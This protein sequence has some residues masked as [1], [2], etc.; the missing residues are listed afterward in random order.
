MRRCA[1][2]LLGVGLSLC[3][4]AS[5]QQPVATDSQAA[6]AQANVAGDR[7]RHAE[8]LLEKGDFTA[9][10]AELAN[11]AKTSPHDAR[12]QYDLG[13]TEEHN[14]ENA[15]A[16]SAY[17]AALA[18]DATLPEP[19]VALGLLQAREGDAAAARPQLETAARLQGAP[20]ALRG[21]ALRALAQLNETAQP[22][23]ARDE[24]LEAAQLTGEQPGDAELTARLTARAGDPADAEAVYRHTLA[25][26]PGDVNAT[27]ELAALLQRQGKLA[28]ADAL[29]TPALVAHPDDLRIAAQSAALYAAEDK[30]PEALTLLQHVRNGD[31]KA[32]ADPA[33]TRLLA[34]LE[35]V[36]GDAAAAE[37]LYRSLVVA[38]PEN[39]LLLDDFGSTLVREQHFAEAQ[40]VLTKAVSLRAAFHDDEA[41]GETAG[42]LAFAASRNHQPQVVLQALTARAT[43]LPNSAAS[44]FLQATAQDALHQNKAAGV[45]YRA[46]LAAAGGKLPDEEFKAR[47]RLVALEHEH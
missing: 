23:E 32:A 7:M 12:I 14:S 45:S 18:A 22:D 39:P 46:F 41:W 26:S 36:S 3:L 17:A 28:E 6:A 15:A 21:R 9:A 4:A 30:T 43:V 47:H 8:D 27:V 20:P 11:L 2:P 5:A 19:R 24:L 35:L 29:L 37:P 33:L 10:E 44:L 1:A 42:H 31:P 25:Q 38:E 40:A 16:A 34:H 13:F